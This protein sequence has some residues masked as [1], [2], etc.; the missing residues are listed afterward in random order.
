MLG[1]EQLHRRI[2]TAEHA[3]VG[4]HHRAADGGESDDHDCK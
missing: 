2:F 1:E 4:D 3:D